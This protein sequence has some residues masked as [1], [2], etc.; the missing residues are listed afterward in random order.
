VPQNCIQRT[1]RPIFNTINIL[2]ITAK[3]QRLKKVTGEEIDEEDFITGRLTDL[4]KMQ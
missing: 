2:A 4:L 3:G 1:T